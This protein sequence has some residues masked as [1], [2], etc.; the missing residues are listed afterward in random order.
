MEIAATALISDANV[1]IDYFTAGRQ[2]VLKLV[3][4]HICEVKIPIEILKEVNQL[5]EDI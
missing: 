3:S 1:L 4:E 5:L 2:S